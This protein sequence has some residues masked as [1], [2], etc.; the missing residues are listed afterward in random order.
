MSDPTTTLPAP[1]T[2]A[3]LQVLRDARD[4]AGATYAD[5]GTRLTAARARRPALDTEIPAAMARGD[6]PAVAT[7]RAERAQ[8][9]VDLPDLAAAVDVAYQR[10]E[11]ADRDLA[12][13]E[14]PGLFPG[15]VAAR[16]AIVAAVGTL[17]QRSDA[18]T[19]LR[20]AYA[21][22]F[23]AA[24][25]SPDHPLAPRNATA[26][27]GYVAAAATPLRDLSGFPAPGA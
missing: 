22:R 16:D 19:A 23:R 20:L 2:P 3:E 1:A 5:L 9:D 21:D 17:K 6:A 24:G 11:A 4:A 14:L 10:A 27:P 15:L 26:L 7:L 13:A 25:Y 8:L 12:R 18:M